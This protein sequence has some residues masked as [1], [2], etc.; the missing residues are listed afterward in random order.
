MKQNKSKKG[1][2]TVQRRTRAGNTVS[3]SSKQKPSAAKCGRCSAKLSGIARDVPSKL[4]KLPSTKRT[5]KREFGGVLCP[6]CVKEIE[7]YRTRVE[8]GCEI[9]RDLTIEKFL[10]KGWYASIDVKTPE[11]KEK[12]SS[13]KK[14]AKE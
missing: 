13:A 1:T 14:E 3:H 5:V 4:K 7:V 12:K 11:T 6:K 9:K 10:P 8:D 2:R